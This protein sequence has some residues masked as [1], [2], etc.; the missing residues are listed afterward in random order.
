MKFCL[1]VAWATGRP[2]VCHQRDFYQANNFHA[3]LGGASHVIAVSHCVKRS[4]PSHIRRKATAIHDAVELPDLSPKPEGAILQVG[5]AGEGQAYKG[6]DILLEAAIPL[7]ERYEFGLHLWGL[8]DNDFGTALRRRVSSAPAIVQ[9]RIHLEPFRPDIEVFFDRVNVV[10][11]PSRCIDAFPRAVT[12]AMAHYKPVIAANHGGMPE[13][14][15][16][17][18]T[19]LLFKPLDAGDLR[20]QL[21]RMLTDADLRRRLARAGRATVES[22]LAVAPYA[23]EVEAIYLRCLGRN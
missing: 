1:P 14:I 9:Q 10:V 21:E 4:L 5:M 20:V 18:E 13:I 19:G 22:R 15:E 7:L 8:R 16:H 17:D 23:K 2:V 11:V 12:E 3:G 6:H